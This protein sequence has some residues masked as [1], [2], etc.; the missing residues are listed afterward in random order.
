MS[1]RQITAAGQ[2]WCEPQQPG[3]RG[4]EDTG[5]P[6]VARLH[7]TNSHS[8]NARL[9]T[10]ATPGPVSSVSKGSECSRGLCLCALAL[11]SRNPLCPGL[12]T[13][14]ILLWRS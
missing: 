11:S 9:P 5:H 6:Q 3:S 7:V 13:A 4:V 2:T 8:D 10:R 1:E 12:Y 14:L